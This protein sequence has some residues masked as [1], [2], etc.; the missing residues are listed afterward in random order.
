[1]PRKPWRHIISAVAPPDGRGV[2]GMAIAPALCLGAFWVAGEPGLILIAMLMPLAVLILR[3]MRGAGLSAPSSQNDLAR[4]HGF[5]DN[6]L[7]DCASGARNSICFAIGIDDTEHLRTKH[8]SRAFE[9]ICEQLADRLEGSVRTGDA[10]ARVDAHRFVAC[11]AAGNSVDLETGLQ[12]AARLQDR[13]DDP[14]AIEG[15]TIYPSVS[16]GFCL[17]SRVSGSTGEEWLRATLSALDDAQTVGPGGVRAYSTALLDRDSVHAQLRQ[18]AME[19]LGLGQIRAWFQ[20]QI[21]TET[22]QITGAEALARWEHPERGTLGPD[23]FLPVLEAAGL[24]DRLG[25]VVM[26]DALS[27]LVRWREAGVDIPEVSVNFSAEQLRN[28]N[29]RD[30]VAWALERHDL[31]PKDL[32]IE[33]L[34]TV[35]AQ[36]PDDIICRTIAALGELGCAVDLDDYGVGHASIAAIRRFGVSRIKIDRSFIMRID[37]DAEQRKMLSAILS[38]AE[39]LGLDTVGEGVETAGEHA[40]LC[41]L[42]CTSVQGYGIAYPMPARNLPGWARQHLSRL[43]DQISVNQ[44]RGS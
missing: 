40:L 44:M 31:A 27:A 36:H 17:A 2:D 10:I 38:M 19:A 7:V 11:I 33:I 14:V 26:Q 8:G 32:R 22:G 1:M 37:T 4:M 9:R 16:V 3:P 15:L 13:M 21:S 42:G 24:M 20:P 25:D 41:Q 35:V 12:V 30:R 34:E 5:L 23:V 43:P 28:P 29:L 39:Q 18:A 6:V